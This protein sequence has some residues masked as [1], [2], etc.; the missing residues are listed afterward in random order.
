[1]IKFDPVKI[2]GKGRGE[3]AFV[4]E[5]GR[6]GVR[7]WWNESISPVQHFHSWVMSNHWETNYKAYQEGRVSFRYSLIPHLG[8]YSGA[9]AEKAGREVCQP[10]LALEVKPGSEPV[11]PG[12]RVNSRQILASSLRSAGEDGSLILR[13]YNPGAE[14]ALA[15]IRGTKGRKISIAYLKADGTFLEAVP[16]RIE[17]PGYGIS[18]F[19][20][21]FEP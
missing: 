16:E 17:L 3:G 18:T 7:E 8:T 19:R 15:E 12:F 2:I 4:A 11:Y 9:S 6:K 21:S 10:L 13:L 5:M 14:A 20:I 1:M